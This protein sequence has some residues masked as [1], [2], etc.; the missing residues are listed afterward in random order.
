MTTTLLSRVPPD[1]RLATP[2]PPPPLTVPA[3]HSTF[4]WTFASNLLFNSIVHFLSKLNWLA[5]G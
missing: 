1:S 4:F 5:L 2:L 3:Q